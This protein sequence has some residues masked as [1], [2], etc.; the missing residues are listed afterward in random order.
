ML[1]ELLKIIQPIN[2]ILYEIIFLVILFIF[3]YKQVFLKK[4]EK[5]FIFFVSIIGIG[6]DWYTWHD[7]IQTLKFTIILLLYISYLFYT[8]NT[9]SRF[10]NILKKNTDDINKIENDTKYNIKLN[11][12]NK[13]DIDNLTYTPIG[14][15]LNYMDSIEYVDPTK[16]TFNELDRVFQ[17]KYPTKPLDQYLNSSLQNLYESPQYKNILQTDLDQFLNNNIHNQTKNSDNIALFKNP[18][19]Q[20]FDSN[21]YYAK[22]PYYNDHCYD[23]TSRDDIV[24]FGYKLEYCTNE[25]SKL[26]DQTLES[27][28]N[29][30]VAPIYKNV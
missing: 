26:L 8:N 9:L 28:N 23:N 6:I 3:I 21:W 15:N 22:L 14:L 18:K 19:K 5:E 2:H 1:K 10:V 13:K 30:N 17:S 24:K 7:Y 16:T 25:Q 27:I 20:F 4:M 11:E 12:Q 29:N